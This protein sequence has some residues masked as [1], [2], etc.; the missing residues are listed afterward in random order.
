M[1]TLFPTVACRLLV[2]YIGKAVPVYIQTGSMTYASPEHAAVE[3][4]ATV[5][6]VVKQVK[7]TRQRYGKHFNKFKIKIM[8]SF[9][10]NQ[11]VGKF[12]KIFYMKFYLCTM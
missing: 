10:S 11:R 12:Q 8:S 1:G 6:A 7:Q 3:K 4:Y 2:S 5:E 9:K